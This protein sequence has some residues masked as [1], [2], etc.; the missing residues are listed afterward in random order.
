MVPYN[1]LSEHLDRASSSNIPPLASASPRFAIK[2]EEQSVA[3]ARSTVSAYS[4]FYFYVPNQIS[5]IFLY[6]ELP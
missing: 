5:H 1:T 6:F 2:D 3:G 4:S